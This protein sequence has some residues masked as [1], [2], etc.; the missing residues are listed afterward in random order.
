MVPLG[1]RGPAV[2]GM[3]DAVRLRWLLAA[4]V[5]RLQPGDKV[6]VRMRGKPSK[7]EA[8]RCGDNCYRFFGVPVMV[9]DDST[10]EI[11]AVK[12]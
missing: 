7:E 6:V 1:A 8:A 4:R 9:M 12:G 10:R 2:R 3:V 11:K 5:L